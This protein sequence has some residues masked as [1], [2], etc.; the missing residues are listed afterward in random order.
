MIIKRIVGVVWYVALPILI[1]AVWKAAD[2]AGLITSYTMP[3]PED[4]VITAFEF[5]NDG[6]LFEHIKAS[7]MRVIEGF[8]IALV[9]ALFLGVVIGLNVRFEKFT[10]SVIQIIKPIPPIAWIPLAILWFG[11]GEASKIYIIAIGAFFPILVN[12]VEG[13]KNI[14]S[15][16]LELARV[17]EVR[18]GRVIW[19]VILPGALPFI[20]VG[21]RIGLGMG[22]IC[23]VAAELI[24]ANSGIGYMLM[25]GRSLSRPDIV[26]LGMIVIGIVG[27]LMDDILRSISKRIIKWN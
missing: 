2:I 3:P 27:K 14:D 4:I 6:T 15:R 22:W 9:L 24:A 19:R 5:Y 21:V 1:I 7:F 8:G 25:D 23:V 20:M 16:Y 12:T 13:I 18:R 10:D 26:I 11:I 17:Y